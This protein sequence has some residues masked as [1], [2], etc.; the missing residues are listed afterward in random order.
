MGSAKY[1]LVIDEQTDAVTTDSFDLDGDDNTTVVASGLDGTEKIKIQIL[2]NGVFVDMYEDDSIIE[3]SS[4][5]NIKSIRLTG[6]YQF[7][8]DAS[9]G[10]VSLNLIDWS[11]LG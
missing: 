10:P 8:K 3:L 6:T 9:A 7:V 4:G 1:T 5:S 2:V 11:V